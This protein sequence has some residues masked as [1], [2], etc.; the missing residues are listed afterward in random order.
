MTFKETFKVTKEKIAIIFLILAF[1]LALSSICFL[2]NCPNFVSY[3][4]GSVFYIFWVPAYFPIKLIPQAKA[5]FFPLIVVWN[6]FL[7]CVVM[8]AIKK[9]KSRK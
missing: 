6:Y 1:F 9:I 4:I 5:F 7:V 8:W 3:I 2:F